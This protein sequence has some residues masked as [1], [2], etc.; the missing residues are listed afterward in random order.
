MIYSAV[1]PRFHMPGDRRDGVIPRSNLTLENFEPLQNEPF[2]VQLHEQTVE[3]TLS[4]VRNQERTPKNYV[5]F[6]L[7]FQGPK[8]FFMEQG[9]YT[10]EHGTHGKF[11]LFLVPVAGD[12]DGYDYEAV[13]NLKKG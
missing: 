10:L 6:S 5:C 13:I 12:E 9:I 1:K 3:L 11:D 8:A 4:E 7:L 2:R